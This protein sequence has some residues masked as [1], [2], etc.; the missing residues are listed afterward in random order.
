MKSIETVDIAKK[1]VFIRVD[2]NVPIVDGKIADTSRIDAVIKTIKYAWRNECRVILASHLG[3]PKGT[4][5]NEWSLYPV[6]EK[7]NELLGFDVIFADDCV[8]DGI[9]KLKADL[10]PRDILLLENLRFHRKETENEE[11][12][13]KELADHVDVYINDA[14]GTLHRAHASV[15]GITRFVKEKACGFLVAKEVECLSKL[16]ETPSKPYVAILGGAKVSDKI[17]VINNLINKVDVLVIGGAMAYT[18]LAAKG[19]RLGKSLIEEDKITTAEKIIEKMTK[20]GTEVILPVDHN[21]AKEL[22]SKTKPKIFTNENFNNEYSAFD[23][24]PETIALFKKS[25]QK[26]R[27]V[28]WNGP[29]GV[30]EQE[31]YALGTNALAHAIAELDAFT[32]VGGG[33]S[34]SAIKKSGVEAKIHHISTGGG[35]SLEFLEGRKLPGLVALNYY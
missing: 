27:T 34:V 7:L 5:R 29:L 14:F 22:Q 13:A 4:V 16:V 28:F 12:F 20:K 9:R 33:D 10:L 3:R 35:A 6:A 30:C 32:V 8:G 24:G 25:I 26:A 17:G 1:C 23:I 31:Q 2:F 21:A 18:F 11:H 19:I 15:D